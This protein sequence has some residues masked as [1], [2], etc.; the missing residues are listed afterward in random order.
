[1]PPND[2]VSRPL[3]AAISLFR[4]RKIGRS[5]VNAN[6]MPPAKIS[7]TTSV[8]VV[9]RQLSQNSA[10]IAMAALISPPASCTSPVPTR[11][12]MPSASFMTR[13]SRMPV[14][15]ESK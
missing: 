1:M 13:E 9:S 3:T 2:S 12:R 15:V 7:S 4:S 14:W 10:A 5:L 11:L 8:T 6:A